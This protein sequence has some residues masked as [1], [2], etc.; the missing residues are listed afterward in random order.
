MPAHS[1]KDGDS[2]QQAGTHAALNPYDRFHQTVRGRYD[3]LPPRL[4]QIADFVLRN[5]EDI[6]LGTISSLATG[7]QVQPSTV[8]RFARTFGF[9]GFPDMQAVFRERLRNRHAPPGARP[10]GPPGPG[11][12]DAGAILDGFHH[13]AVAS[14]AALHRHLDPARLE[15]A[16]ARLAGARRIHILGLRR[17]MPAARYLSYLLT[18]RDI[19]HQVVGLESGMEEDAVMAAGPQDAAVI[20]SFPPYAGRTVELFRLLEQ[21]MVP[22]VALTDSAAS[23]V[24]P[25]SGLWLEVAEADFLGVRSSA[26]TMVLIMTLATAIAERRHAPAP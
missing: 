5:P 14:L 22:V 11:G 6:A 13:A 7:A 2:R 21:R 19:A 18:M 9:D 15:Q 1:V 23:P 26:A 12:R 4:R 8:V 3:A 17:S 20:I 10:D 24:I 25:A 16:V